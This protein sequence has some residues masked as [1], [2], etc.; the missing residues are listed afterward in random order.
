VKRLIKKHG[1]HS[2]W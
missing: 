1:S 2:C